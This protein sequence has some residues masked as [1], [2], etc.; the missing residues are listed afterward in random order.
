MSDQA[1]SI[2]Q[3]A[4]RTGV[5]A[6]TLRY[7]EKLGLL[8]EVDRD[9]RSGHRRYWARHVRWVRFLRRMRL[10]GMPIATMREYVDA[11]QMG[12]QVSMSRRQNILAR[13]RQ[14]VARQIEELQ[15]HLEIVDR[16]LEKGC[17]PSLETDD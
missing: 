10:A 16:K 15:Q 7:Y 5:S 3:L 9:T 11:R 12:G 4:E 14:H 6:H 2:A 17:D 8:P 13:H 1:L